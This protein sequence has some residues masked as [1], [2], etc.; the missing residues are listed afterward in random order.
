MTEGFTFNFSDLCS[1]IAMLG[2]LLAIYVIFQ[3]SKE[4]NLKAQ[5][6][7]SRRDLK[8][9][10]EESQKDLAIEKNFLKLNLKLDETCRNIAA[11]SRNSDKTTEIMNSVQKHLI[12]VDTRLE[13]HEKY[14]E[15]HDTRLKILEGKRD[16]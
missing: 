1:G 9:Q 15:D 4:K 16:L 12:V 14:L 3:K 2:N 7:D 11:I 10:E 8:K 13:Q 5:K 6:E